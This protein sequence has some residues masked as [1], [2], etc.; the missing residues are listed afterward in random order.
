M[1]GFVA[2]VA[3]NDSILLQTAQ[4]EVGSVDGENAARTRILFDSGGQ[5]SYV[6]ENV[7]KYMKLKTVRTE[8]LIIKTFGKNDSR[9]VTGQESC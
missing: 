7:R 1:D 3:A 6:S 9:A 2:H 5:Q 8:R 4:A